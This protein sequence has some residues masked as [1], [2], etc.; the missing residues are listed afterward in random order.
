MKINPPENDNF[1]FPYKKYCNYILNVFPQNDILGIADISFVSVFSHSKTDKD[2]LAIYK[3]AESY[4]DACVEINMP[5]ILKVNL[6]ELL[7]TLHHELAA[8]Y[9]SE[10]IAHEIGHHV[11]YYKRHGIKK[12]NQE[13]FADRYAEAGLYNYLRSRLNK[14]L[15]SCTIG[16][17]MYF[18]YDKN[19]RDSFIERKKSILAFLSDNNGGVDFP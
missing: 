5:N 7:F 2:A 12:R 11:H 18:I 8:L 9:L 1:R 4:K 16:S 19:E 6:N 13:V 10:L 17:H 14:I 3:R 15:R